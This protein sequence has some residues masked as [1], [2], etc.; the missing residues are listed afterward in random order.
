[1][2]TESPPH[3]SLLVKV[4]LWEPCQQGLKRQGYFCL[5]MSLLFPKKC[6][7]SSQP[8]SAE[9]LEK[10]GRCE[11]KAEGARPGEQPICEV[12]FPSSV[13][14]TNVSTQYLIPNICG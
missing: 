5:M 4:R 12:T 13:H 8:E 10:E 9:E 7:V 14:L 1:V 3:F 6:L 11:V 2:T